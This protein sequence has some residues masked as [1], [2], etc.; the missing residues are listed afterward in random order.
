MVLQYSVAQHTCTY[1]Y[2]LQGKK[3]NGSRSG[4]H[5]F[6]FLLLRRRKTY[7]GKFRM[8]DLFRG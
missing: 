5:F 6:G 2:R 7:L 1:M 3:E 8:F 4:I